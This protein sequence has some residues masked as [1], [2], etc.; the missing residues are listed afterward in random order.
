MSKQRKIAAFALL[1]TLFL[2]VMALSACGKDGNA[3][4]EGVKNVNISYTVTDYDFKNGVTGSV[5]GQEADVTVDDSGVQ[6]GTAGVYEVYYTLGN[7]KQIATVR[8]YGKPVVAATDRNLTYEQAVAGSSEGIIATDCFGE[9]LTPVITDYGVSSA[10][11]YEYGKTYSVKYS[12]SDKAGNTA[13]FERDIF[14]E[15]RPVSFGETEVDLIDTLC[16]VDIDGAELICVA[17]GEGNEYTDAGYGNGSITSLGYVAA[18]LGVGKHEVTVYT[19]KAYGTLKVTVT[20]DEDINYS[21]DYGDVN[22]GIDGYIYST[23]ETVNFPK[24]VNDANS[25]QN[26]EVDYHL[27]KDG[28][29]VDFDEFST[30]ETGKY[31]YECVIKKGNFEKTVENSFYV[32]E[33]EEKI[34]SVFGTESNQF[35]SSYDPFYTNGSSVDYAGKVYAGNGE[36][37][38]AFEYY[39]PTTGVPV[40]Y[41]LCFNNNA[42][43]EALKSGSRTLKIKVL[44]AEGY[45]V[46]KDNVYVCLFIGND[47]GALWK[48]SYDQYIVVPTSSR[49][50]ELTF[51]ISK[52]TCPYPSYPDYFTVDAMDNMTLNY[53]QISLYFN[54]HENGINGHTPQNDLRVYIADVSLGETS[55]NISPKTYY[56]FQNN[57]TVSVAADAVT[58]NKNGETTAYSEFNY[59][60]Y[61]II[62]LKGS[63]NTDLFAQPVLAKIK[64]DVLT[65]ENT[66]YYGLSYDTGMIYDINESVSLSRYGD[67][68]KDYVSEINYNLYKTD[69][70]PVSFD[71]TTFVK[72]FT[73]PGGYNLMLTLNTAGGEPLTFDNYFYVTDGTDFYGKYVTSERLKYEKVLN[74][75]GEN[76]DCYSLSLPNNPEAGKSLIISA[77][78]V[79]MMLD[80]G[81]TEVS[82]LICNPDGANAYQQIY[83]IKNG[84]I[85]MSGDTYVPGEDYWDSYGIQYGEFRAFTFNMDES[86][87]NGT[88]GFSFTRNVII[89]DIVFNT[90]AGN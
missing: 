4:I 74:V 47:N 35:L 71:R 82:V 54:V 25:Y 6:F 67:H 18:Y 26:F 44:F 29:A 85:T 60:E 28:E 50:T 11:K 5:D 19:T 39:T 22:S 75:N 3:S 1:I 8:I 31:T 30:N 58:V 77:E 78:Y 62:K 86:Y 10:Y 16:E 43:L 24:I 51:D 2:A 15:G 42:V 80:E 84:T 9:N 65:F 17:D 70:T 88:F 87:R 14:I 69:G 64:G 46:Y 7:L 81:R 38:N 56:D 79:N 55:A 73:E 27:S 41:S 23:G 40:G 63:G 12:V 36:G 48:I 89:G 90:P 34:N 83:R 32:V 59:S 57:A 66:D 53:D 13:E 45:E 37:Y 52:W 61:G 76:K 68:L 21:F 49:W 20:D 72:K 33:E